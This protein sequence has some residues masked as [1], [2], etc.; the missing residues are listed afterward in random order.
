MSQ[1]RECVVFV[2]FRSITSLV[3]GHNN[4]NDAQYLHETGKLSLRSRY[5]VYCLMAH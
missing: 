3:V 5:F 2:E 1:G 4:Y